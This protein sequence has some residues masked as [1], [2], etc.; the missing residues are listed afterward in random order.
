MIKI[1]IEI[2]KESIIDA[3]S[4]FIKAT[5]RYI[6]QWV[7]TDG[8]ALG[9]ILGFIHFMLFMLV[10]ICVI[11]SHTIYRK[12]WFQFLVFVVMFLTW[13]QHVVLKVCV[14]VVAEKEFTK[15]TSPF[16]DLVETIFGIPTDI[17]ADNF[18]IGETVALSF[19]A[20]E[21]ITRV[22]DCYWH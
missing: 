5:I 19:L 2:N 10:A 6:Y 3:C 20:L 9:Y 21:L 13:L 11:V 4:R 17:L 22:L 18:I 1:Q 14:A 16:H 12:I 15:H 8:E 7:T